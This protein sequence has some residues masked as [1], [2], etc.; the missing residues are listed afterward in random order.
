MQYNKYIYLVFV[1][2]FWTKAPKILGI[3]W[4]IGLLSVTKKIPLTPT[5]VYASEVIRGVV[6]DGFKMGADHQRN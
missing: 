2:Y 5:W 4:A 6:L 3:S 1:P